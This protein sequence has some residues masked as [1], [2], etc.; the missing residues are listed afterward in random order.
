MDAERAQLS[1]ELELLALRALSA[2]YE[3]LNAT[4]FRRQL[5][6]PQLAFSDARSQL[7]RWL[8]TE[9]TIELSRWLLAEQGWGVVVEVLKHEMAHQFVDEVL[10]ERGAPHSAAFRRVCEER[11]FDA[12]ATGMPSGAPTGDENR[13]LE[14]VAKLLALAES[15][16]E[17]EAHAA[18][19]AAQ[20]LMLKYNID[21]VH[22]KGT[23]SYCFRHLGRPSGRVDESQ[24]L[25]A[26]IISEFF[27][28]QGIWVPVWRPLE[29]K[30]GSVFEVCGTHEN[31]ELAEYVH[32]YL[33]HTAEQLWKSYKRAQ[34]IRRNAERR[35]F[36]AGVMTGFRDKLKRER[37]A[38]ERHGLVWVG[39]PEL[40][41][42]L[43]A[44]H[45][46][47]RWARYG[48]GQR[49]GAFSQGREAGREIVLKRGVGSGPSADAPRLLGARRS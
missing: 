12:R 49:S 11:G 10:G 21:S 8:G 35:T 9:R 42:F 36:L 3:D 38:A 27:F 37:A 31:V 41:R 34:G 18:M 32:S 48:G 1:V 20:R 5:R 4:F 40:S 47:V 30:R 33:T 29:G 2:S 26:G 25:L 43:R 46:H 23:Q 14:R 22:T 44:R 13:V 15:P 24:R 17:H 7:G 28:V 45:P 19:A 6:R 16:N 39:D